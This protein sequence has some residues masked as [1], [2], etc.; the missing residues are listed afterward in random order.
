MIKLFHI[1]NTSGQFWT[2]ECWGVKEARE[3]Y[4]RGD[5]FYMYLD[6]ECHPGTFFDNAEDDIGWGDTEGKG[7]AQ[8]RLSKE[9][10]QS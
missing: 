3:S 10:V 5:L 1:E 8:A 6:A 9:R 4:E 2:G 7:F